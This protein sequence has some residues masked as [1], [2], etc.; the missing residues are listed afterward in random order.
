MIMGIGLVDG[1][2]KVELKA[3]SSLWTNVLYI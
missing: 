2:F 3:E 1:T